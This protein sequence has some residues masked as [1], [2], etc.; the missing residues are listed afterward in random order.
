MISRVTKTAV[1]TV[2]PA[3]TL[4]ATIASLFVDWISKWSCARFAMDLPQDTSSARE[5]LRSSSDARNPRFHTGENR[6]HPQ[7]SSHH[8]SDILPDVPA[9]DHSRWGIP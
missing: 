9:S 1:L 3:G 5:E 7:G 2:V 8:E 6:V 4:I